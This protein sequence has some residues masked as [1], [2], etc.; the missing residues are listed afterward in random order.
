[1][2]GIPQAAIN[3]AGNALRLKWQEEHSG[4]VVALD[5]MEWAVAAIEAAAPHIRA[6]AEERFAAAAQEE[7]A[8]PLAEMGAQIVRQGAAAERERIIKLAKQH[9]VVYVLTNGSG[10]PVDFKSFADLI[11]DTAPDHY[12]GGA[13]LDEGYRDE[14]HQDAT[15]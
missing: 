14:K 6:D 13:S 3:A 1:M 4:I 9:G 11:R 5:P 7:L 15:S 12:P 8:R 2:N 10:H